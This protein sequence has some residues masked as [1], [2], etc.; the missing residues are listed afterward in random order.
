MKTA[1]VIAV[2]LVTPLLSPIPVFATAHHAPT[3]APIDCHGDFNCLHPGYVAA[4]ANLATL[5]SPVYGGVGCSTAPRILH[6][7]LV[8]NCPPRI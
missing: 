4:I 1:I 8:C 2:A 6:G 7:R 3:R 5:A